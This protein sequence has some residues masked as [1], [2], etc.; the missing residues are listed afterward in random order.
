MLRILAIFAL[1]HEFAPWRRLHDFRPVK[2]DLIPAFHA[3]LGRAEVTAVLLGLG[4]RNLG[5]LSQCLFEAPHLAVVT[6]VAGGLRV[7][8]QSGDILVARSVTEKDLSQSRASEEALVQAAVSS[9]ARQVE[10]FLCLSR[11]LKTPEEKSRFGSVAD[12]LEMESL[13]VMNELLVRN[14]PSVAVRVVADTA[15]MS[16][17]CDFHAALNERGEIRTSRLL[18]QMAW[19]PRGWRSSVSFALES[20]RASVKL[21]HFLDKYVQTLTDEKSFEGCHAQD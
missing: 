5:A 11:M 4:A 3:V 8:H 12:A 10:R 17:P 15:R 9:G 18:A 20:Y 6:G 2:T 1:R 14:I 16:L 19:A 21:A 7:E 13:T